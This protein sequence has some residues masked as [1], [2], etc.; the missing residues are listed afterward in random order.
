[1]KDATGEV[2]MTVVTIVIIAF[3]AGVAALLFS[4]DNPPAKKWIED[5]FNTQIGDQYGPDE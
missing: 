4:G 1:M 3:I 5:I 2:S